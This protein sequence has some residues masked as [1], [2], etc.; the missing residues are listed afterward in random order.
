MRNE[1]LETHAVRYADV[2]VARR[3]PGGRVLATPDGRLMEAVSVVPPTSCRGPEGDCL[4]ELAAFDGAER[5]SR[6]DPSF[7]GTREEIEI[8]FDER[9]D[10]D[11]G[12]VIASRQ[13]LMTTYLFYQ[14][15]S[16]LGTSA[17]EWIAE[18]ERGDKEMRRRFD[19]MVASL[20]GIEVLVEGPSGETLAVGTVNESGPLATD[21]AVIPLGDVAGGARRI[22]LR[23]TKGLWRLD[24]VALAELDGEVEPTRLR[25]TAVRCGAGDREAARTCLLDDAEFL[26]TLPG[27]TYTLVYELPEEFHEYE[28]LLETSGYYLEWMRDEW[29]AE[30]DGA[31]ALAMFLDPEGALRELAP[32]FASVEAEMESLFWSSRYVR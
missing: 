25:P 16:Y 32:D 13:S 30:E 14:A 28:L 11:V 22:R 3:P 20:G 31:R 8:E 24:Y 9:V 6:A 26:T 27:D 4:A 23:L 17:G 2:L 10:G 21:V 1:A 18:L 15:L 5:M 19:G 12:V 7:L 29:V